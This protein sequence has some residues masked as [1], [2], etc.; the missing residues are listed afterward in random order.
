MN[1]KRYSY[2]SREPKSFSSSMPG[3]RDNDQ[4]SFFFNYTTPR[5]PG[6]STRKSNIIVVTVPLNVIS[7]FLVTKILILHPPYAG[8]RR[9]MRNKVTPCSTGKRWN[10][11]Y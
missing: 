3:T 8:H 5:D 2:D 9:H 6:T 11:I 1:N 7:P 4:I 10:E